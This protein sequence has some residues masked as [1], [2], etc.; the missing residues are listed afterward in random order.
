MI[1]LRDAFVTAA[2]GDAAAKEA[3]V[4][5]KRASLFKVV[6]ALVTKYGGGDN[7]HAVASKALTYA[8]AL[9]FAV[10]WDDSAIFS[11]DQLDAPEHAALASFFKAFRAAHPGVDAWCT[12]QTAGK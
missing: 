1:P 12:A 6:N 7:G 11:R 3:Y 2:F 8:D 5:T 4:S 9:L 10:L